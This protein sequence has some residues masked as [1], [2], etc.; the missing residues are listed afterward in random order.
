MS[1]SQLFFS[2]TKFLELDTTLRFLICSTNC[3][4][5]ASDFQDLSLRILDCCSPSFPTKSVLLGLRSAP[6][7]W[8]Q[9]KYSLNWIVLS[10]RSSILLSLVMHSNPQ[11][12]PWTGIKSKGR[13][14]YGNASVS[15][16]APHNWW[17]ELVWPFSCVKCAVFNSESSWPKSLHSFSPSASYHII[18]G[19]R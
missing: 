2:E 6:Q 18:N 19:H 13:E 10:G 1:P 16:N 5:D 7:F 14:R 8:L 17:G 11:N 12:T 9:R 15:R 3:S 4:I